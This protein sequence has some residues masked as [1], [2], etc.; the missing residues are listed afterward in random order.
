MQAAEIGF[1]HRGIILDFFR[2]AFDQHP[3]FLQH[4]DPFG[5]LEQVT[6]LQ[7]GRVLVEGT[8]EEIKNNTTV[9]EA[10]LGGLHGVLAA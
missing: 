6:V 4:G 5:Q 10:Y 7:E 1:L 8:P 2:R 3:A 9:Q